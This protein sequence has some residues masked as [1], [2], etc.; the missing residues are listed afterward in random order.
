MDVSLLRTAWMCDAAKTLEEKN[1]ELAGLLQ[2]ADGEIASAREK[3]ASV[4]TALLRSTPSE[5]QPTTLHRGGK[6]SEPSH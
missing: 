1:R 4:G 3:N 5:S 2:I 6:H